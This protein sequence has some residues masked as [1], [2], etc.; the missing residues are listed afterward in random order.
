MEML[1]SSDHEFLS[2]CPITQTDI[3]A[4]FQRSLGKEVTALEGKGWKCLLIKQN[5]RL[6][7]YWLAP[8]GPFLSDSKSLPEA[9][10]T[11]KLEAKKINLSWVTIEPFSRNLSYDPNKLGL[12]PAEKSYNPAHTVIND[13][14]LVEASRWS[15]LSPTYRNLINRSERRGLTFKS[16]TNP[17]DINI[18][19]GMIKKVA[20]RKKISLHDSNYFEVQSKILMPKKSSVLELAYFEEKPVAG[21]VI[22]QSGDTAHY[23]YAGSYP[24]ARKLEA[25]TVLLWHAMQNAKNRGVRWF[26][27]F[28][29]AP[30]DAPS[31]HPWTGFSTF[32]RKFGGEDIELGGTWQLP[33]NQARYKA[34]RASLPIMRRLQKIK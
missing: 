19:G 27:L 6:G 16:S 15:A 5:T 9:L 3:W 1:T 14:G 23:A 7:S 24:E 17:A 30:P 20:G 31:S 18:F 34:Y 26:D 25:G 2:S 29:V 32:K 4:E 33:V 8:Y 12:K 10:R 28:G 21:A 11:I 22:L 13:L